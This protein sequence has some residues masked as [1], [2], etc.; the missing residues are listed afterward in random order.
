VLERLARNTALSALAFGANGLIALA[1]VPVI[2][3]A[4]GVGSFGLIVLARTLLP[5]GAL[6]VLDFGMAETATQAVGR[7]RG[8]D[9]WASASEQ[10]GLLLAISAAVGAGVSLVLAVA[11]PWLAV[12]FGV[13]AAERQAFVHILMATAAGLLVFFPGLVAEG[14]VKGFERFGVLRGVEVAAT[15]LYA[16]ATL[17]SVAAGLSY[18]AVAYAFLGAMAARYFIL[19]LACAIEMRRA[20]L[21]PR[22]WGALARADVVR[23][24]VLMFQSKIL[25]TLQMPVPPLLI[26]VLVGPSGVGLYEIITRLPRFLKSTLSLLASA[27]LPV[28]ARL[29]GR[30]AQVMFGEMGLKSFSL[31]PYITFPV[32]FGAAALS[33]PILELWVGKELANYWPWLV[34]MFVFPIAQVCMFVSQAMLQVR[35]EYIAGANRISAGGIAL[36][37]IVSL[38]LVKP[39]GAMAFVAG[40][41]AASI[42]AFPFHLF[43]TARFLAL[44]AASL[45][46]PVLR[47]GVLAMCMAALL[48]AMQSVLPTAT[49]PVA[50][51]LFASALLAY[52]STAYV[53]LLESGSRALIGRLAASLVHGARA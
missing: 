52:W 11:A 34:A 24:S 13:G 7:A 8:S 18:A 20:G 1:L 16:A 50:L 41:A 48:A 15:L 17:G 23:R 26:G 39:L 38:A 27:V 49:V 33:R 45:W 9:D 47:H 40:V 10:I 21:R 35:P 6:G 51:A 29:D 14:V 53:F 2:V 43:L 19:A 36:Q 32:L 31:V 28:A 12:V 42:A 22:R 3:G 5:A 4:Y 44:D 37:F 30:G 46:K 25:G